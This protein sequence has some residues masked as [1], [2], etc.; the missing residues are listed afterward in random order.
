MKGFPYATFPKKAD[1]ALYGNSTMN[2]RRMRMSEQANIRWKNPTEYWYNRIR[3]ESRFYG[4][5][6]ITEHNRKKRILEGRK[7]AE[8]FQD[9]AETMKYRD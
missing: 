2:R 7:R 9:N 6:R 4:V 5:Q 1:R 3:R 8:G